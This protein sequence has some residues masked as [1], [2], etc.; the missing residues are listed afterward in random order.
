MT[1]ATEVRV[2]R[3]KL[4]LTQVEFGK[5]I[6]LKERQVQNIEAGKTPISALAWEKV[7]GRVGR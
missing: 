2:A 3:K 7:I 1:T 6:F 4:G 5:L